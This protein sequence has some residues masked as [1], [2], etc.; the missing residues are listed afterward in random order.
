[1][2]NFKK[3]QEGLSQ[4]NIQADNSIYEQW[5]HYFT[6]LAKWNKVYN[7]T[8]IKH[9]DD[10]LVRHLLDSLSV[11]P[12]ITGAEIADI[13]SGGGLPSL[14]LA[15]LHP[16]KQFTLIDCVAKKVKFLQYVIRDLRLNNIS[17]HHLRVEDYQPTHYFDQVICRAFSSIRQF[18]TLAE[19]L[20]HPR[21]QLLAMK[22]SFPS[23]ELDEA[24]LSSYES[25]KLDVPFLTASRYLIVFAPD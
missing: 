6:L 19:H 13:G 15:M 12:F 8:G 20:C 4:L 16:Q 3:L 23:Q 11:E 7:L 9:P 10:I 22:G 1:M 17:A 21:G 25:Y 14:P 18:K 5:E 24:K 2:L